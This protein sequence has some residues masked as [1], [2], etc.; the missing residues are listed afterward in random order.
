MT[1]HPLEVGL[2][3]GDLR[4]SFEQILGVEISIGSD[5]LIQI[6]LKFE[7][8]FS[9]QI[10]L[11]KLCDQVVLEFDLLKA[12][13][14]LR[15]GLSGLLSVDF[16]IFLQLDVL[17]TK[18]LHANS[19]RLLLKANLCQLLLIHLHLVFR[20]SF[21][22]LLGDQIAIK[23]LSLVDFGVDLLLLFI[24]LALE[25]ILLLHLDLHLG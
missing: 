20:L 4:I 14:V 6:K 25:D 21:G 18:L 10:L 16:F 17:L 24:D 8:G 15:V 3:L 5:L 11:L 12:L 23:K 2:Q 7:L 22:L 9:F 1:C 19:I 13:I